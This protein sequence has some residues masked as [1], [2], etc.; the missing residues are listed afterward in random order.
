MV[1]RASSLVRGVI[2]G[3]SV[4]YLFDPVEGRNRRS[5]VRDR[6]QRVRDD[7][8]RALTNAYRDL[9]SLALGT[10]AEARRLLTGADVPDTVLIERVRSRIGHVVSRAHSIEVA[11]TEGRVTLSGQVPGH[12]LQ[13]LISA[14]KRI[15]G[16]KALD[17]LLEVH[18]LSGL[19]DGDFAGPQPSGDRAAT[20]GW[21]PAS[22]LV[23]GALGT[24]LVYVALKRRS[25]F[26]LGLVAAAAGV[27]AQSMR[28]GQKCGGSETG[29][30]G[31]GAS[32]DR[33]ARDKIGLPARK[34][35]Q[36]VGSARRPVT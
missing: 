36:E 5:L 22:T 25:L 11:S 31:G 17:N 30:G 32:W 6:A 18:E 10:V 16:V 19:Q 4:M 7:F 8:A 13:A 21:S 24:G 2:I 15:P 28:N 23:A 20:A 29:V 26:W 12:E 3:A 35:P 14:V 34:E 27:A 33:S 9:H 1:K